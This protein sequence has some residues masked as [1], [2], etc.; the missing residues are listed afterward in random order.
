MTSSI[1]PSRR[2]RRSFAAACWSPRSR[3]T[4]RCNSSGVAPGWR[5][6]PG[7]ASTSTRASMTR[8]PGAPR[9]AGRQTTPDRASGAVPSPAPGP[10]GGM[11]PRASRRQTAPCAYTTTE[12]RLTPTSVLSLPSS[13][14][15]R[16]VPAERSLR[17]G[18][19]LPRRRGVL[20][21]L[22][23][24]GRGHR[25]GGRRVPAGHQAPAP[26]RRTPRRPRGLPLLSPGRPRPKPPSWWNCRRPRS[27]EECMWPTPALGS[28]ELVPRAR[29]SLSAGRHPVRGPTM[30]RGTRSTAMA[31]VGN[32]VHV[33]SNAWPCA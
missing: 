22:R 10:S 26:R 19:P 30:G 11:I 27:L 23:R 28:G 29:P 8:T 5:R 21:P 20:D 1:R 15:S 12:S 14:R 31:D 3:S 33:C 16:R 25:G 17:R 13:V 18:G 24:V 2:S 4:S 32:F 7:S 6:W 9:D